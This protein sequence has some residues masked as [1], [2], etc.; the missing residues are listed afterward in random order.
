MGSHKRRAKILANI[1]ACLFRGTCNKISGI[2]IHK[3]WIADVNSWT[4][5]ILL[6]YLWAP[7]WFYPTWRILPPILKIS[8]TQLSLE[9]LTFSYVEK[10][11]HTEFVLPKTINPTKNVI[12]QVIHVN[13]Y[14]FG[15][16]FKCK[17]NVFFSLLNLKEQQKSGRL[18]FTVS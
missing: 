11:Y 12:V 8:E 17:W 3:N 14:F 18:P 9:M 16:I 2:L 4:Q 1:A 13:F 5:Y 15:E 10:F 6:S 7:G